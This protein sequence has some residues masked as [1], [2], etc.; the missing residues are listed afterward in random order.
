[1]YDKVKVNAFGHV[2]SENRDGSGRTQKIIL[3]L[4]INIIS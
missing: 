1:M 4:I 3:I 2:C